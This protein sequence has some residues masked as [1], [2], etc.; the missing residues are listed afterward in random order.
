MLK[1]SLEEEQA[2]LTL[3]AGFNQLSLHEKNIFLVGKTYPVKQGFSQ[4]LAILV[5]TGTVGK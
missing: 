5:T 3:I 4:E 2:Y 1:T